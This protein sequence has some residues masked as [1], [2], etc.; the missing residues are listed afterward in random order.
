MSPV[1]WAALTGGVL[2]L[3]NF[4]NSTPASCLPQPVLAN[5]SNRSALILFELDTSQ[6][7]QTAEL[8]VPAKDPAGAA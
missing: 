1:G 2:Y 3:V 7:G 8:W 4:V 6:V 5:P